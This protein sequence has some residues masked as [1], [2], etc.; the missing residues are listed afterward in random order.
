MIN[1]DARPSNAR[2]I[3]DHVAVLRPHAWLILGHCAKRLNTQKL[4][5]YVL[6]YDYVRE[7]HVLNEDLPP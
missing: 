2:T 5:D 3:T 7:D 4:G 6:E 1:I